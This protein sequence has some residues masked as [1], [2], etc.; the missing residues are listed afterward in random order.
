MNLIILITSKMEG[1]AT[2]S[3]HIVSGSGYFTSFEPKTHKYKKFKNGEIV[4]LTLRITDQNGNM[5]TNGPGTTV[6]FHIC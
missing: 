3:L 4:S 2:P 6:M 5:I 1:P